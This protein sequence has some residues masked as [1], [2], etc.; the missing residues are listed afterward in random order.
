LLVSALS[1]SAIFWSLTSSSRVARGQEALVDYETRI[2]PIFDE[3][4][5]GGACH[6]GGRASGVDLSTYSATLTSRGVLYGAPA[7][8]PHDSGSSPLWLKVAEESP[9]FGTRMPRFAPPLEASA[10][11]LIARWIDEGAPRSAEC[12]MRGDVDRSQIVDLSDAVRILNY[13]FVGGAPI[14]CLSVADANAN[15]EIDLADPVFILN[16]LFLGGEPLAELTAEDIHE[17]SAS[18]VAPKA[19]AIG[20]VEGRE[21]VELRFRVSASDENG[22][23]LRFYP[24]EVPEGLDLDEMSGT[25][26]WTPSFGDAGDHRIRIRVEDDRA[27]PL[28]VETNGLIRISEGNHA[29]MV[30]EIPTLYAREGVRLTYQ[31]EASDF[32]D[33]SLSYDLLSGPE[34]C[35]LDESGLLTWTPTSGQEGE[36]QLRVRVTDDGEPSLSTEVESRLVC[37]DADSPEN[38]VPFV[39]RRGIY[40]TIPSAPIRFSIGATDPD[41]HDLAFRSNQLPDGATLDPET[42]EFAWVPNEDQV[43]AVYVPFTV[44]DD[45]VPPLSDESILVFQV[46]PT[47]AC[48]VATCD[49]ETGCEFAPVPPSQSCCPPVETELVRVPEPV[50]E[51]PEAR[52]MY[53]GRNNRGFGRMRNC[54][55]LRVTPFPQGGASVRFHL[56]TR[57]VNHEQAVQLEAKL[58]SADEVIFNRTQTAV[59]R[60]RSDG[61]AQRLGVVFSIGR[62]IDLG[63][64]E[65]KEAL[66]TV[67]LTDF[68]GVVLELALRVRLTLHPLDD[69]P[70]PDLHDV[71][72]DEAGCIGCH[73]P[74][75][76]T[77]ERHGIEDAHPWYPL[78]CTDCHGGDGTATFRLTAHV[79]PPFGGREYLRDLSADQL[80]KVWEPQLQF[81]NPSDLRVAHRGCGSDNPANPGS[82][83]HQSV[84]DSVKRSVMST[85]AGH[86]TLPR[87]LA[88]AQDRNHIFAAIDIENPDYDPETA[89]EGTVA[90]LRALR[91]PDPEADRSSP[92]TCMDVYLPKSCPTCHLSDFGPNNAAGNFRS[93][94]CAAC[95]MHY[96]EDGLSK[97]NDPTI[98]KDFPPHPRTHQLTSAI[99]TEQCSRCHFQGGRIGL[100]YRGIRE[101]GFD[102]ANTPPHAVPLGREI[103]DHPADYYFVDEDSRND[104][105]ETPPDLHAEAGLVCG[106]CHIGG[107][108]HGD[109]HL[110][111]S[112]RHQVG[113]LC[114]DCHGS[115]RAEIQEDPKTGKF[116]NAKGFT[117]RRVRR[118][119]DN[120]ILLKLLTDD[121]EIE[122]PQIHRILESGVNQAMTQAM[123]VNEHGYSH[124]DSMECY[125]CHTSWRLTCFGCHVKVDDSRFQFNRTT[126]DSSRGAISV[127]RDTYSIDFFALGMNHRGKISPLCSSMSLF[128]TYENAGGQIEYRNRPRIS[129]DGKLGFGWN[130][131]HH[132]TVSRVPQNCDVCHPRSPKAGEDNSAKLR[133]TYGFGT[134]K[135]MATDGDGVTHDLSRFLDDD[136]ELVGDFPHEN[137]GPVPREIRERAMSIEVVPQPRQER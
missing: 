2:Q 130:P 116:K 7:V 117:F 94:G 131:F 85:Y 19:D 10:I 44:E 84:V 137:T 32:D 127:E 69:L 68:D 36:Y 72:A 100:A 46:R 35:E 62:A 53:L 39:P 8:T 25:V 99:S 16:Y 65:G 79:N 27:P 115:V 29:P 66:L 78:S 54:D 42:G 83:C 61:W 60:A 30:D 28:S 13:L 133:E 95:H 111:G 3:S 49:P 120:R 114:E 63:E 57:C 23:R 105:D 121:R 77:G 71:I 97:S 45:G 51:C 126:G 75:G 41:G 119:E 52:I 70:E 76:P 128:L 135:F 107:D 43:G 20:T 89:P 101:G 38:Q 55:Q 88:G 22:D 136:G 4:C 98:T 6:V 17:C 103:H 104:H 112:E 108:V 50:V 113:V 64:L 40:R 86:Y 73:N 102:E 118:T 124:T 91:E 81:V 58:E 90:F 123:G 109:G 34:G 11:D 129:S 5:S 59:L 12:A 67:Q 9:Q 96:D 82:G 134:G 31:V 37:V 33:D 125:T 87:Y 80:D 18:N 48:A 47:D 106:D 26:A 21:G 1:A 110:Y 74:V 14:W 93:S 92:G 122:I 132:H 24:V 56:E 15:G